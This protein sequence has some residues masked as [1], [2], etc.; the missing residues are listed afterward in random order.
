[1]KYKRFQTCALVLALNGLTGW[2]LKAETVVL[3][4]SVQTL[5][6]TALAA[7]VTILRGPPKAG[8]ETHDTDPDGRFSISTSGPGI[9]VVRAG[10]NGYAGSEIIVSPSGL[11]SSLHFRLAE[12]RPVEGTVRSHTGTVQAGVAVRIRYLD[13]RRRMRMDEDVEAVTDENGSFT[14]LA[15]GD[16]G[17]RFVVD[18]LPNDW[19]T[20]SSAI[21]GTGVGARSRVIPGDDA[22]IRNVLIELRSRGARISGSVTSPADESPDGLSPTG[23]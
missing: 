19:V 10:A 13:S 5:D 9:Q 8:I 3:K 17:G 4:G 11:L 16:G 20:T 6:G 23:S 2:A 14:L 15:A 7:R 1:M 18:A 21:L 22:A 12:L